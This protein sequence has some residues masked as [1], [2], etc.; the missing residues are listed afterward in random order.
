MLSEQGNHPGREVQLHE[1][2]EY[3]Q[4]ICCFSE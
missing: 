2:P 4:P 3:Q 1:Y